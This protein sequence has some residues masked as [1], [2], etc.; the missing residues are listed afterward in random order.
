MNPAGSTGTIT[1]RLPPWHH[2]AMRRG[3]H[4]VLIVTL[5]GLIAPLGRAH[6]APSVDDNNRYIKVTPAA[7]RVRVAYTVFF[8]EVPGAQTRKTIDANRDGQISD[9]EAEAFGAKIALEVAAGLEVTVDRTTRPITWSTVSV[10]MGTPQVTAGAFSID[11]VVWVCLPSARGA[12][13]LLLRDRFRIPRPGETEVKVEDGL[14]IS[15]AHARVGTVND[16]TH[17]YK[18]LGPG[19]PLMDDG[20]DLAFT[21]SAKAPLTDKACAGANTTSRSGPPAAI[22]VGASAVVGGGLAILA[23]TLVRKRRARSTR[24][25]KP[26]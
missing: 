4:L 11:M 16:P 26:G 13:T 9:G 24:A 5:L 3:L 22:V 14:G 23:I 20:L 7:D 1:P 10:G 15:I 12:H 17:D 8:G 19:G 6:I 21:A 2:A 25:S 18:F